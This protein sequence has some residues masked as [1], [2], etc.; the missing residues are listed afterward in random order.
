MPQFR[1]ILVR[2]LPIDDAAGALQ[3]TV[4]IYYILIPRMNLT[5]FISISE[6]IQYPAGKAEL[7]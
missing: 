3:S 6:I 7:P 4:R 1:A 5:V 2:Q